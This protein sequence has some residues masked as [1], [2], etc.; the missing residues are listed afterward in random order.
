MV[1]EVEGEHHTWIQSLK[2]SLRA[3]G[4]ESEFPNILENIPIYSVKTSIHILYMPT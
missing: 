3:K 1:E 2:G 4:G